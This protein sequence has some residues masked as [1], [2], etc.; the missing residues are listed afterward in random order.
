[1]PFAASTVALCPTA[2]EFATVA[3]AELPIAVADETFA[4]HVGQVVLEKS[5]NAAPPFEAEAPLP[6]A[7][8]PVAT[9]PVPMASALTPVACAPV[10]WAIAFIIVAC[11]PLP[12][13]MAFAATANAASPAPPEL[14]PPMAMEFGP[15]ANALAPTAVA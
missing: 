5:P 14:L 8:E 6:T 7:I 2:A 11:A 4:T 1:V 12:M 15:C 10:P 9:A 3:L 13:A